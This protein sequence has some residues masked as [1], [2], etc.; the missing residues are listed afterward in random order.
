MLSRKQQEKM[1]KVER[2]YCLLT[3]KQNTDKKTN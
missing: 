1:I 2:E 3:E